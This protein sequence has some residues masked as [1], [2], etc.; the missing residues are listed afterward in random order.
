MSPVTP[1]NYTRLRGWK[2]GKFGV[3]VAVMRS[4]L[5]CRRKKFLVYDPTKLKNHIRRFTKEAPDTPLQA[6]TWKISAAG[7]VWKSPAE[8]GAEKKGLA[9]D[10]PKKKIEEAQKTERHPI[11]AEKPAAVPKAVERTAPEQPKP[12]KVISFE[13]DDDNDTKSAPRRALP[14]KAT[15]A[16]SNEELLRQAKMMGMLDAR[17]DSE[18]SWN[19][20]DSEMS[21]P[22][23]KE[24]P[25]AKP[26]K[27][28]AALTLTA[29]AC[30]KPERH[31]TAEE[32]RLLSV[33]QKKTE[34][35]AR[36]ESIQR[37]L[38]AVDSKPV[39]TNRVVFG[40]DDESKGS[41]ADD[42]SG[43]DS[44]DDGKKTKKAANGKA[45]AKS[46]WIGSDDEGG[47][48][49]E[50]DFHVNEVCQAML[51]HI[52]LNIFSEI[53]LFFFSFSFLFV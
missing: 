52:L 42:E 36:L 9:A 12:A 13:D 46:N 45:S 20:S 33:K 6:L 53:F 34:H 40:D 8:V 38:Q 43:E 4:F 3:P 7:T 10:K 30:E 27:P 49:L 39:S 15:P 2:I 44:E 48:E 22:K 11:V 37:A 35:K 50:H 5:R 16:G 23:V 47:E 31:L 32:K 17:S 14:A 18:E 24:A 21:V 19:G 51:L 25:A 26:E 1:D 28:K 41:E 29:A